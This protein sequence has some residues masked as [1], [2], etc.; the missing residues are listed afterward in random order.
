MPYLQ[1]ALQQLLDLELRTVVILISFSFKNNNYTNAT[2]FLQQAFIVPR[3]VSI[4]ILGDL[5]LKNN[6][7]F[8]HWCVQSITFLKNYKQL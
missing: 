4:E 6:L 1:P 2:N 5:Q 8:P 7:A 3:K